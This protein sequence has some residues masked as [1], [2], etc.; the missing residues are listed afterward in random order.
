MAELQMSVLYLGHIE[1]QYF[2]L[3]DCED[4][5]RL[6]RSP[7]LAVLIQHSELGNI[8]YDTGNSP[9]HRIE[10]GDELNQIYP[11]HEFISIEAA[12][13][14]KGLK[15]ADIDMLVLSHLHFDHVGG[16]RYFVGTKAIRNIVVAEDDLLAACK[17]VY[18]GE[19]G[20][21]VKSLFDVEGAVY[22]PMNGTVRLADNLTLFVQKSHTPGVIG[23]LLKTKTRGNI[24]FTSDTIYTGESMEKQLPPGGNI[25][26]TVSEFYDNVALIKRMQ[27]EYDATVIFGHDYEQALEWAAS[28]AIK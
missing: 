4:N 25:N 3:V 11:V 23:M 16:L 6:Y 10:N 1:T 24:I 5:S 8:L 18:T 20:A 15:C 21:Y 26:K 28:G 13:N 27:A 19:S 22:K 12:L 7:M 9:Y 14:E 2:Q 17:S